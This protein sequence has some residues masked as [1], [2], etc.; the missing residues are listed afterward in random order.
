MIQL[1]LL[2]LS[3]LAVQRAV[4][5]TA[6]DAARG[7]TTQDGFP[8]Q[9]WLS[10]SP[11]TALNGKSVWICIAASRCEISYERTRVTATLHFPMPLQI[12]LAGRLFG[13]NLFPIPSNSSG[14]IPIVILTILRSIGAPIDTLSSRSRK[15]PYVRWLVRSATVF[16]ELSVTPD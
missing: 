6:R 13:E 16:N 12:P 1:A 15:I 14:Q 4:L 5:A 3:S 9:K 8:A 7:D 11:L 10:L 2:G